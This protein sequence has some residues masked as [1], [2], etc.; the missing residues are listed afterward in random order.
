M[1]RQV[2]FCHLPVY[3]S[4]GLSQCNSQVHQP[5]Q[6]SQL[7]RATGAAALLLPAALPAGALAAAAQAADAPPSQQWLTMAVLIGAGGLAA[8]Q[9]LGSRTDKT[10]EVSA[11]SICRACNHNVHG[12]G[13]AQLVHTH[14]IHISKMLLTMTSRHTVIAQAD[15]AAAAMIAEPAAAVAAPEP[16]PVKTAPLQAVASETQAQPVAEA[17]AAQPPVALAAEVTTL[18]ADGMAAAMPEPAAVAAAPAAVVEPAAAVVVAPAAAAAVA[19]VP[20]PP[21]P[22]AA[23]PVLAA[24]TDAV[25][26]HMV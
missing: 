6:L 22:A 11:V 7:A 25:P 20:A 26:A 21:P 1:N 2:L 8:A 4:N 24:S 16:A 18:Q 19:T 13:T 14:I 9:Q 3:E 15:T 23:E 17:A 5:D 12:A 10:E